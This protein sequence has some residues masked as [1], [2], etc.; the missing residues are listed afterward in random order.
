MTRALLLIFA[1]GEDLSCAP[2]RSAIRISARRLRFDF[3]VRHAVPAG[4]R[5]LRMGS[6]DL[7]MNIHRFAAAIASMMLCMASIPGR[8]HPAASS[9]IDVESPAGDDDLIF[10]SDFDG[11]R[12]GGTTCETAIDLDSRRTYTAE[13]E[14][15]PNWMNPFGPLVSPS[16]D[17]VYTFVA[18]DDPSGFITPTVSN[19]SVAMYLIPSCSDLG[20][21][22]PPIGATA[23]IGRGINLAEVG[24]ISGDTYYLA[25]TG[26]ASGGA[27]ANGFV[28]FTTPPGL[29]RR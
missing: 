12:N 4:E 6:E 18:G 22:P 21:E 27:S 15:T 11:P 16:H 9:D 5:E 20:A 24:L 1:A 13:T 7:R 28:N 2:R 25:I 19:Y 29:S 8:A 26:S 14:T 3:D 17:V 10:D 23:T